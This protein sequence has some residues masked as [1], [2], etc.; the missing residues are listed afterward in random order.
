MTVINR[1]V[2]IR[3]IINKLTIGVLFTILCG[4]ALFV[5]SHHFVN[6]EVT[7]K[8]FGLITGVGIAGILSGIFHRNLYVFPKSVW[9]LMFSCGFL[10]V[11]RDCLVSGFDYRL[12]VQAR[13]P[14][15][16]VFPVAAD[17]GD[18]SRQIFPGD[19]GDLNGDP[20]RGDTEKTVF[21][22]AYKMLVPILTR[23]L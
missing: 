1:E 21:E 17:D 19:H 6:Q 2:T 7:P 3:V 11:F 8:W 9:I 13:L 12:T 18:F 5:T 20:D 15:A 14:V 22:V 16:V 10:I 23:C 4:I